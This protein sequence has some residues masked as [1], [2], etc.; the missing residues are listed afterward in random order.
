LQ[1]PAAVVQLLVQVVPAADLRRGVALVVE[2]AQLLLS[3]WSRRVAL[4]EVALLKV[5][6]NLRPLPRDMEVV[7]ASILR[8]V[9]EVVATMLREVKVAVAPL[10]R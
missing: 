7:V 4:V 5:T 3:L 1:V 8:E 2:V 10:L 9:K 6:L